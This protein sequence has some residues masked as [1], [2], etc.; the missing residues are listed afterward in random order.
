MIGT[1]LETEDL[2]KL[3]QYKGP[4]DAAKCLVDQGVQVLWGKDGP[5]TT[6]EA[7]NKA[8]GVLPAGTPQDG[9]DPSGT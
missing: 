8:L 4:H 1:V 9:Y 7:I 3:T 2:K 6:I 5:F